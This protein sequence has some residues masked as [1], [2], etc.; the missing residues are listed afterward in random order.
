MSAHFLVGG[1][2]ANGIA[3]FMMDFN[4]KKTRF[5]NFQNGLKSPVIASVWFIPIYLVG[6]PPP[7]KNVHSPK[8]PHLTALDL[9]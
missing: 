4:E 2:V 5:Q 1:G 7:E 6:E 8:K 9:T 3:W